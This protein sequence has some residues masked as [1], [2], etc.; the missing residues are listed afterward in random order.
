M[1]SL[2]TVRR[3]DHQLQSGMHE[4]ERIIQTIEHFYEHLHIECSGH[5]GLTSI[6]YEE[7]CYQG[8]FIR[9]D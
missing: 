8:E 1:Q 7:N 9:C 4:R 6:E 2:C 5:L 3:N